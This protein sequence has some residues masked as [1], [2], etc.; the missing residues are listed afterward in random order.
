VIGEVLAKPPSGSERLFA[1]WS[2]GPLPLS[3]AEVARQAAGEIPVSPAYRASRNLVLV[4]ESVQGLE[5][6]DWQ[7]AVV[8]LEHRAA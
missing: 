7:A 2:R 5:R 4:R 1:V 3:L 6:E 8:E